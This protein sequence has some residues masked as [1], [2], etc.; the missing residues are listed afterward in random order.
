[1]IITR[2]EAKVDALERLVIASQENLNKMQEAYERPETEDGY[3]PE[4]VEES[5]ESSAKEDRGGDYE[6]PLLALRRIEIPTVDGTDPVGR[7]LAFASSPN[8][9]NFFESS[10]ARFI[11]SSGAPWFTPW[12]KPYSEHA[13]LMISLALFLPYFEIHGTLTYHRLRFAHIRMEGPAAHWF[14]WVT[15]RTPDWNWDRG[16]KEL[17]HR[18]SGRKAAN[19]YES[20][21]SL[22]QGEPARVQARFLNFNRQVRGFMAITPLNQGSNLCTPYVYEYLLRSNGIPH[23]LSVSPNTHPLLL[24]PDKNEEQYCRCHESRFRGVTPTYHRLRSAHRHIGGPAVHVSQWVKSRPPDWNWDRDAKELIHRYSGR[25]AANPYEAGISV[26][27]GELMEDGFMG[28]A[29]TTDRDKVGR[30]QAHESNR[31]AQQL[32][33]Q[34]VG[35]CTTKG[36][37]ISQRW[38]GLILSS[39]VEFG[40][41]LIRSAIESHDAKAIDARNSDW[42][43]NPIIFQFKDAGVNCVIVGSSPRF[44]VY[45][46]DFGWGRPE[47]VRSGLNNKFDGRVYLYPGK[48]GGRSIEFMDKVKKIGASLVKQV[49]K[50]TNEMAGDGTTC[51]TVLTQAIFA[52]GSVIPYFGYAWVDR[53]T[54]GCESIAQTLDRLAGNPDKFKVV[55]LA[56]GSNVTLLADQGVIEVARHPDDVTVVTGIVGCAGLKP[57]VAAIEA[58]KDITSPYALDEDNHIFPTSAAALHLEIRW[59]TCNGVVSSCGQER[60][61][62][63]EAE[64][65]WTTISV[66]TVESTTT[67]RALFEVIGRE[68]SRRYANGEIDV[69]PIFGHLHNVDPEKQYLNLNTAQIANLVLRNGAADFGLVLEIIS[70]DGE[71]AGLAQVYREF[72][73]AGVQFVARHALREESYGEPVRFEDLVHRERAGGGEDGE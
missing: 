20:L 36:R 6:G 60:K 62:S 48:D 25:K 70:L 49:A 55:A 2:S 10:I 58:G 33:R 38:E 26:R 39:P 7:H 63:L 23:L 61:N 24:H 56:A 31:Q 57:T 68:I 12:K 44:K 53:K 16:A 51:A 5:L 28:R 21:A 15:L 46:M 54:Q 29:H 69:I 37:N 19:P 4:G 47:S 14:Q 34:A 11:K 42:E 40:A 27:Q 9:K 59:G 71:A 50:A 52:E 22:R 3:V 18:Y 67:L 32:H 72:P 35:S 8:A 43:S 45:G 66:H 17:I 30:M 13:S 1:M 65:S 41:D 64:W 73:R